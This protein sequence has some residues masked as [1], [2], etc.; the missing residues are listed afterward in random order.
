MSHYFYRLIF[1]LELQRL[2]NKENHFY[3]SLIHLSQ[4]LSD[5]VV[6]SSFLLVRIYCFSLSFYDSKLSGFLFRT[7]ICKKGTILDILDKNG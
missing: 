2:E 6:G 3:L 5:I 4:K 1:E 7:V